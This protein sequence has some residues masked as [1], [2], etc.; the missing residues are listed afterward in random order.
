MK[1]SEDTHTLAVNRDG[2]RIGL[3]AKVDV[4]DVIRI[5][6]LENYSEADFRV[7]GPM[8][9]PGAEAV[10]GV[11]C[12]ER[13][14]NIWG[15][16]FPA[17]LASQAGALL[18]CRACRTQRLWPVTLTEVEVL[19]S[20]GVVTRSCGQCGKTTYWTYAEAARRPREFSPSEPTAPPVREV[21]M[22]EKRANKRLT[23]RLPI[24]VRNR[25][26]EEEV[27]KTD[28]ISKHGVAVTLAVELDE[29]EQVEIL[30][31]YSPQEELKIWQKGEVRRRDKF[32]FGG[33]RSYGIHYVR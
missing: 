17:P 15:I 18:E 28:D 7:V 4:D 9:P 11:E 25:R 20:T 23:M 13:G 5:A 27:S 14:R 10:W 31:P 12:V 32:P 21:K 19:D 16:E 26:G 6:N 2:A 29:G 22:E 1:F 30:C 33:R 3:N 24:L 8:N